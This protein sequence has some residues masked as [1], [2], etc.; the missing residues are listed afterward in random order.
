MPVVGVQKEYLQT[1]I[2]EMQK[3]YKTIDGYFP[4]GAAKFSDETADAIHGH[5]IRG[6]QLTAG[7]SGV[8][9]IFWF[10]ARHRIPPAPSPGT[11]QEEREPR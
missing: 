4:Q 7:A 5:F 6:G 2:D 10:S 3:R 8:P 11:T 9:M 1:A